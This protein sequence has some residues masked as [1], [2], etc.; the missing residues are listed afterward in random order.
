MK[1]NPF[2]RLRSPLRFQAGV[3]F[4]RKLLRGASRLPEPVA[5]ARTPADPVAEPVSDR[6]LPIR[7]WAAAGIG[8]ALFAHWE[9]STAALESRLFASL[10][11]RMG[12]TVQPGRSDTIHFPHGGPFDRRLGYSRLPQFTQRLEERGFQYRSQARFSASLAFVT[13]MGVPPPYQEAP[14]SGLVIDGSGDTPLYDAMGSRRTFARFEQIPPDLVKCLL[15][16]EN[17]EL[18]RTGSPYSNPAIDWSRSAQ[19]MVVYM[20]SRLGLPTPVQGGS[21]LAVQMEKYRHSP[22]GRTSS[23]VEKLRQMIGASLRVYRRGPETTEE[24]H[25]IVLDYVNTVPLGGT[26]DYGEV[27]GLDEAIR[28]WFGTEP[29][30]V[31]RALEKPRLTRAKAR[32]LKEVLALVCAVRAPSRYLV[33]DRK[34]LEERADRYARLMGNRGILDPKLAAAVVETRLKFA[35]PGSLPAR[36]QKDKATVLVRRRLVNMLALRD[37]Y[38]LDRLHLN[39]RTT[40]D[41]DLEHDVTRFFHSLSSSEFVN[42]SG[43][44]AEHLLADGDPR[45]VVYSMILRERTPEGDVVR[46]QADNV[47]GPLDVNEGTKMELGSTAKLRTLVHYLNIMAD[48]HASLRSLPPGE[49][50]GQAASARDPLTKWAASEVAKDPS[51]TLEALLARALARKYSA[52]PYEVFF[53]GGGFLTFANYEPED[54]DRI[55]SV[56]EAVVHSTN[57]VFVRLMRDLVLYH[58][59]HLPY[60]VE[61]VL[62]PGDT[63]ERMSMLREVSREEGT[64]A[65]MAWL[66]RTRNR[67]AQDNRLRARIERDAF[68]RMTPYWRQLGFPFPHLVPSYATAIGSSSDQPSA[69]ADLMGVLSNDGVRRPPMLIRQ[70]SFADDTPYETTLDAPVPDAGKLLIPPEVAQAARGVLGEVVQRGTAARLRGVFVDSTGAPIWLG[71]KTGTGD[72]RF[73]TYGS[74]RRVLSSRAVSRTAAFAF[75]LG[76]RYYGVITASVLGPEADRYTFTSVLPVEVLRMLAP[77]LERR[78]HL[79][80]GSA[81]SD[82]VGP[83]DDATDDENEWIVSGNVNGTVAASEPAIAPAAEQKAPQWEWMQKSPTVRSA[84]GGL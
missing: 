18:S 30:R 16:I 31:Y 75:C 28:V 60:D 47:D 20:A 63:P 43:L 2:D 19:G 55:L 52:S 25:Q 10:A 3:F 11:S 26:R 38:E 27:F 80:G 73:V 48:L 79:V 45:Q 29:D 77:A 35:E 8:L 56:R 61:A 13:S 21:T 42:S 57:L 46:V 50:A 44:R 23:A 17:R 1:S 81:P 24:R 64:P 34:A 51:I 6:R 4:D 41:A 72:N 62:G 74:G 66:F 12:Y 40:I 71:G 36:D 65:Q 32:A 9:M 7:L 70:V 84:A 83:G 14:V 76:D 49:A 53:T 15:F 78:L 39:V 33:A 82:E 69:L 22:N 67:A 54:N 5:A 68:E 59:A 58:E 37:L